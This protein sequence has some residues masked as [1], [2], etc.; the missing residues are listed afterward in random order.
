ME[1][2]SFDQR[3]DVWE[4]SGLSAGN[5]PTQQGDASGG[6]TDQAEQ[7][8]NRGGLAGSV[9][10]EESVDGP[11]GYRKVDL[12]NRHLAGA[13]PLSEAVSGDDQIVLQLAD[14]L[15]VG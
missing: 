4:H 10:S 9:R 1:R 13:E 7:H 3:A 6:G 14:G 15:L 11:P 2:R 5:V 8:A 12:V